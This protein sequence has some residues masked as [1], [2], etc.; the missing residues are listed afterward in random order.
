[1]NLH[2]LRGVAGLAAGAGLGYGVH[3]WIACR[4]GG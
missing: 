1:M 4:G 2:R 3:R